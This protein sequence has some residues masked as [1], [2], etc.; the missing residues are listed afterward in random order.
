MP[1]GKR[2]IPPALRRL[3]Q[4]EST[5]MGK[6]ETTTP[7][8][9]PEAVA[10]APQFTFLPVPSK[11][12]LKGEIADNAKVLLGLDNSMPTEAF[13]TLATLALAKHCLPVELI[14]PDRQAAVIRLHA[15]IALL[16]SN[17]SACRQMIW[18]PSG[19]AAPTAANDG[20]SP[21]LRKALG[22]A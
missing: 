20:M 15:V 13:E 17:A 22:L 7:T 6:N 8:A 19:A 2:A 1:S 4:N 3:S 21:T 9:Q 16:P 12:T 18:P 11:E 5:K 14:G 10:P